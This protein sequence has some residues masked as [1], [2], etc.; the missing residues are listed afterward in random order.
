[1]FPKCQ[2]MADEVVGK[3]KTVYCKSECQYLQNEFN[4]YNY[5]CKM[6]VSMETFLNNT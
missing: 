1:M 6:D 4:K 5:L 3:N 2:Q